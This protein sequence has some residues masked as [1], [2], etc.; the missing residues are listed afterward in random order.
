M[1]GFQ[2][3]SVSTAELRRA[4]ERAGYVQRHNSGGHLIYIRGGRHVSLPSASSE[5]R[6]GALKSVA[7]QM[8]ISAAELRELLGK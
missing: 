8:G 4:L 7:R 1:S 2:M 5:V 6:R 3:P